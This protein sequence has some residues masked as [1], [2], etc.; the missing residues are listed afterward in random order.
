MEETLGLQPRLCSSGALGLLSMLP[1]VGQPV[2]ASRSVGPGTGK[3]AAVE[4]G[5]ENGGK[6]GG[7][8][9]YWLS[10]LLYPQ[11]LDSA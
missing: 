4:Q 6:P 7:Q 5:S 8:G 9:V 11:L 10:S 1:T 2:P 3:G